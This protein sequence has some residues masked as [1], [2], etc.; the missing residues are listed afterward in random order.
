MGHS[1]ESTEFLTSCLVKTPGKYFFNAEYR[2]STLENVKRNNKSGS[3][4][5]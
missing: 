1:Y 2:K 4:R 5:H 3:T